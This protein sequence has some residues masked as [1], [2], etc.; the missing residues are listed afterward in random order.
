MSHTHI[1]IKGLAA[2]SL[3]YLP[4]YLK[5]IWV[6]RVSWHALFLKLDEPNFTPVGIIKLSI[7]FKTETLSHP[8]LASFLNK[9]FQVDI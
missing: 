5:A 1:A 2:I 6:F 9:P 3:R 7:L 4:R 8:L